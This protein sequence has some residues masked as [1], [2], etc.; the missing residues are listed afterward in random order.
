MCATCDRV[1]SDYGK[2]SLLWLA[3]QEYMHPPMP[4]KIRARDEAAWELA[5][6]LAECE[7]HWD[8]ADEL[9]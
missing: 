2:G 9:E 1:A 4:E 3:A 8:D 6:Y 7:D 5:Q